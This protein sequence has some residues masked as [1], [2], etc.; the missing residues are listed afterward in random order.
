MP[1]AVS[2]V[3]QKNFMVDYQGSLIT[4]ITCLKTTASDVSEL[5]ERKTFHSCQTEKHKIVF[6]F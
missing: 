3:E 1:V 5:V 6:T 2:K 4:V